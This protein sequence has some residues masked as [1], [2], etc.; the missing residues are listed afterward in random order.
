MTAVPTLELEFS[1]I[2]GDPWEGRASVRYNGQAELD[3]PVREG[4]DGKAREA[5]RWYVEKFMDLPEGGNRVR[6]ELV[7]ASLVDW[8]RLLWQG[9]AGSA[10]VQQWLGQVRGAGGG[11]LELRASMRSNEAAFRTPWELMRVGEEPGIPLHLLGVDVVRRV[12]QSVAGTVAVDT[13]AGLR[14]LAIVCRPE[15][16][17]FVDPRYTP[18]A[19]L[20]ALEPRPEVSVDFARPGT[21]RAL[22]ET[23][24]AAKQAGKP[25]HVLHFN[26]HGTTLEQEGG[27]GALCFERDDGAMDL[28]RAEKLGDLL[29]RFQIPL[30]VLEACR[31]ATK[32]LAQDTV[33]GA[34]LRQGVGTVLAMG[35]AVHIDMTRVLM[36]TLYGEIAKGRRVGEALQVARLAVASEDQR[37]LGP[38]AD[39]PTVAL[40]DWFVPQL[41]QAGDDLALLPVKPSRKARRAPTLEG[42]PPPPQYGFQG[43]GHELHRL[44]RLLGRQGIVLVHGPGGLGKTALAAEAARWWTRTGMFP[45]GA[46]FVSFEGAP[47][48]EAV[49]AKVGEALEGVEFHN[50]P[51][52]QK[53]LAGLLQK[54]R[55]LV[56][57]DNYESVLP[58][59][60]DGRPEPPELSAL[61]RA[62][63]TGGSRVLVTCRGPETGL[64]AWAFALGELSADEGVL[65]V[66]RALERLGVSR[67][68]LGLTAEAL[69]PLVARL[70]G[71]PLAL[72]LVAPHLRTLSV[73]RVLDELGPLLA[74]ARQA[75]GE[76]RNTSI[77][78]SL[79][80]STRHLSEA[81]RAALPALS[82]LAGG[83]MEQMAS[84]LIP[85]WEAVKPE[86][87]RLGLARVGDGLVRPH[88][89]LGDAGV[90]VDEAL[91]GRFVALVVAFCGA[92]DKQVR[93][94]QAK[95]WMA[96][97][98]AS[99]ATARRGMELAL[100]AGD[101]QSAWF[102]ADS[103]KLFLGNAGRGSAGARLMEELHRR[104]GSAA[105][106]ELSAKLAREAAVAAA[107]RDPAAAVRAL[108]G[109]ATRLAEVTAW[110]ARFERAQVARELG[111]LW[112]NVLCQPARALAP[113]D[114]ALALFEALERE[115]SYD[116]ANRATVLGDRANALI[117]LGR[118]DEALAAA[119]QGLA[120]HRARG[121]ASAVA[122]GLGQ[123]AQILATQGRHAEAEARY[124]EA[125]AAAEAAG[126]LELQG[127]LYQSLGDLAA[128]RGQPERA[129]PL[130]RRALSAFQQAGNRQ[131]EMQVLNSLG[132]VASSRGQPEAA[133][134]WFDRC[135]ERARALGDVQGEAA[136]RSNRAILLSEQAQ[137][138]ADQAEARRLLEA[139][140][141]EEA[142]V[143]PLKE[144]LG[145]PAS[146]AISH[147]NLANTLRLLG[148]LDEAQD[149]ALQALALRER[150]G[151]P[152]TWRTLWILEDIALA[153]PDPAAAETWRRRKEAARAEAQARAGDPG[154]PAQLV[155]Q[156]LQLAL[157]AR[158][159]GLAL[160]DALQQAGA[161]EGFLDALPPWLAAHLRA[162]AARGAS[163]PAVDVPAAFTSLL[164]QAWAAA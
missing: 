93:T 82:L 125:L 64:G 140:A 135:L 31:T 104:A 118:P 37:R 86:L 98:A 32:A 120:L 154:L 150:I 149:H 79:A 73:D 117:D 67:K 16:A 34:L 11:R 69:A 138:S 122:R 148:R 48:A 40:Q 159:A 84:E 2:R 123:T 143:L 54:R 75:H 60:R 43:R 108:E 33:A 101:G 8:G 58:A 162:L 163:R 27:V 18:E 45:D 157:S 71:H 41:Y 145:Q 90:A 39:A 66:V 109:L 12:R 155:V 130:L 36:G 61:A 65:L 152:N 23:L 13:R 10:I 76:G 78:A 56:V 55:V 121:D 44:E 51:D 14:V 102:V 30:V 68:G 116:S 87:V 46:V 124:T 136:A 137:R 72:E 57:W 50:K 89:V 62:W 97:M 158:A 81:T 147:N 7:E 35:H 91:R 134:A 9:L 156:L 139:A 131:G 128:D 132:N 74:Q 119:K 26:G 153:R 53:R 114:Q 160:P 21:L 85:G 25:Y 19:I 29:A 100:A 42:F 6:A 144:Q 151:H 141:A 63:S 96:V 161:P 164:D 47:D 115:G 80:F 17:G 94:A 126:D 95:A 103:L 113:L 133:L 112:S 70:G 111:C 20:E 59:F 22:T 4:M 88:P 52:P 24:E 15:D 28:V 38:G 77:E 142:S 83:A 3:Y 5:V 146:L 129:E 106:T 127:I 92:F 99:E 110:D 1:A 49:V 107:A 105:L